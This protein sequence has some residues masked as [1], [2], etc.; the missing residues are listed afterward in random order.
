MLDAKII[1]KLIENDAT[2]DKKKFAKMGQSY[3]DG[4]HDIKDYKLY[5]YNSDGKVVEDRA[6]SNIKLEH[7]FFTE[8]VDQCVQYLLSGKS[9]I[10]R[11]DDQNLQKEL[12]SYFN[13]T[14]KAELEKVLTDTCVNGF[15]YMYCYKNAEDRLAF[16]R[17]AAMGVVEVRAN[18]TSVKADCILYWYIDGIANNNQQ[19]KRI[20]VWDREQTYYYVQIGNGAIELDTSMP[21]NPRPHVVYQKGGQY[22]QESLGFIP[23]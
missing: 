4:D 3:Y 14:F 7:P 20:Q 12:D 17:A 18:E 22:Y 5:Y 6:R 16:E 19:I 21:F 8:L 9:S 11:A 1:Q 10:V 2:S 15:G 23:F 13:D